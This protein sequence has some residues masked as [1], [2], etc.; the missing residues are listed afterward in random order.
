MLDKSSAQARKRLVPTLKGLLTE[1]FRPL[2]DR[3]A[4]EGVWQQEDEEFAFYDLGL[5]Q[6]LDPE[7]FEKVQ[8]AKHGE[9]DAKNRYTKSD[10]IVTFPGPVD[11]EVTKDR[12]ERAQTWWIRKK[13]SAATFISLDADQSDVTE[14]ARQRT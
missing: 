4:E 3:A 9:I 14:K 8:K 6:T 12:F 10:V 1:H 5:V 7:L 11:I 2:A 13:S